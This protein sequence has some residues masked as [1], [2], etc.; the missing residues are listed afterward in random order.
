MQDAKAYL[1]DAAPYDLASMG[2]PDPPDGWSLRRLH[3]AVVYRCDSQA[4]EDRSLGPCSVA[5]LG[6]KDVITTF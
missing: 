1:K 2:G 6:S 3:V 4:R 5:A